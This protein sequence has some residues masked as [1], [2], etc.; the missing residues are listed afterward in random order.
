MLRLVKLYMLI[1]FEVNRVYALF[2][3]FSRYSTFFIAYSTILLVYSIKCIQYT[4]AIKCIQYTI[5]TLLY[6]LGAPGPRLYRKML[7]FHK[8]RMPVMMINQ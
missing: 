1:Y 8:F 4:I 7:K 2:I 6:Y 5:A 3:I